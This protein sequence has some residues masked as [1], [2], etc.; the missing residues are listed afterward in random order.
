MFQL[1]QTHGKFWSGLLEYFIKHKSLISEEFI[2]EKHKF[3]LATTITIQPIYFV[4][5]PKI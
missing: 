2:N 5:S 3:N 1:F 4:K